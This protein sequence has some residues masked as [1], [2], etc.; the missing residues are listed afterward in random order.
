LPGVQ[1][2][3]ANP[4]TGNV[5]VRFDPGA[6]GAPAILAA[7]QQNAKP[8]SNG[9]VADPCHGLSA[10]TLVRSGVRGLVGHAAVDALWFGAGFLGQRIGLPLAGLGPLHLLLDVVVW[11]AAFSGYGTTANRALN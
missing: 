5:L 8:D 6:V 11:G 3:R 4:L 1:A 2:V 7:L 9:P 10:S